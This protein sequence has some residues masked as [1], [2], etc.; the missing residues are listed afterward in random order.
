MLSCHGFRSGLAGLQ[1]VLRPATILVYAEGGC[2]PG[3]TLLNQG[4][5][6]Q[7]DGRVGAGGG[8]GAIYCFALS[9]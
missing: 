6:P 4:G 2:A 1:A 7:G 3:G 9:P 8:Y 5:P